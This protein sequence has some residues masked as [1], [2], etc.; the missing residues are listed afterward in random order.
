MEKHMTEYMAEIYRENPLL[1]ASALA[2]VVI[3]CLLALVS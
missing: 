3:G 2:G 1:V